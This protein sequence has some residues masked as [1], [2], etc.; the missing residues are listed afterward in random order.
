MEPDKKPLL[1]LVDDV[2]ENLQ[3]LAQHLTD[4]YELAFAMN[5]AQALTMANELT[6]ALILLDVMMPE[7]DGY[8]T[9]RRL[10]LNPALRAIPVIF[11]TAK[12]ETDAVVQGFAAGG[13]DYVVKPFRA[14]ELRARV[15]THVELNRLKSLLCVCAQC[16]KIRNDQ[17][18]WEQLDVYVA[19]HTHTTF[20]HGY[21]PECY[22]QFMQNL[23]LA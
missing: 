21:C 17:D 9:C 2:A 13:V 12:V 8:E 18:Q 10:K 19:R 3:L 11:L 14:A 20:S 7:L 6:P 5:G 16:Q 4:E 15:R 23:K 22:A 1:L